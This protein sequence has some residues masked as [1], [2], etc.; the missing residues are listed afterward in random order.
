MLRRLPLS[1]RPLIAGAAATSLCLSLSL[2]ALPGAD[3][4]PASQPDTPPENS[5]PLTAASAQAIAEGAVTFADGTV[6]TTLAAKTPLVPEADDDG[7][8]LTNAEE[9]STYAEGGVTYMRYGSHPLLADTDGDGYTDG[10][11]KDP[12]SWDTSARDAIIAQE[13]SYRSPDYQ[14]EVLSTPSDQFTNLY[15]NRLEFKLANRELGPYWEVARTWDEGSGFDATLFTFSNKTLPFLKNGSANILAIRGTGGDGG[16]D[17]DLGSDISLGAGT[18]PSQADNAIALA[19]E[20]S[21]TV[22]AQNATPKLT[23]TGHSLG[24]FL[25]QVFTVRAIGRPYG[26]PSAENDNYSYNTYR[27]GDMEMLDNLQFVHAYPFNAPK[28]KCTSWLINPWM[29]QYEL[30]Y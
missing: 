14:R 25:T 22:S 12:L 2:L 1:L 17:G 8:G 11:D 24:G 27:R 18:W 26:E 5:V 3:A 6:D 16:S 29:C 15:D 30:F 4:Q 28:I 13:L 21:K 20:M 7:D 10:A 19:T 9:V 23:V